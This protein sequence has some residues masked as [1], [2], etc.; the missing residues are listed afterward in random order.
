M[1]DKSCEYCRHDYNEVND[2]HEWCYKCSVGNVAALVEEEQEDMFE[3]KDM[4]WISTT[5]KGKYMEKILSGEKSVEYKEASEFWEK[6]LKKYIGDHEEG[7]GINFICGQEVYK[8]EVTRVSIRTTM[9]IEID[10]KEVDRYYKIFL[11]ERIE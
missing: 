9:S 3:V 11:G 4:D 1:S 10:G 2:F 7:L 5:I 8:F 6:R